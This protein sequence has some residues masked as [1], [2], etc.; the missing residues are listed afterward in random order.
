MLMR[1][2]KSLVKAH[3]ERLEGIS[4]NLHA[5]SPLAILDIGYSICTS[6]QTGKAV[7]SSRE[8]DEG[9]QVQVRLAKG[10]LDC[11]VDKKIE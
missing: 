6:P 10:K 3:K 2:M 5:L 11:T 4:K 9:S 8:V 7:K 1:E